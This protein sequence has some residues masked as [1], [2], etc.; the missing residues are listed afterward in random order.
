MNCEAFVRSCFAMD[1]YTTEEGFTTPH[2]LEHG[3]PVVGYF[4]VLGVVEATHWALYDKHNNVF[5]ELTG[6]ND[7]DKFTK[8]K[9]MERSFQEWVK[10]WQ[11]RAK[12]VW[13]DTNVYRRR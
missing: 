1:D 2:D 5:I 3:D 6:D 8:S 7:G 9:I 12:V 10:K 13:K 4:K 11:R